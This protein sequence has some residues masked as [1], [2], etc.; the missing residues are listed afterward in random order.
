[1]YPHFMFALC[2]VSA[3]F[4][5]NCFNLYFRFQF[6]IETVESF[7][8]K[9]GS[10]DLVMN[11]YYERLLRPKA[12]CNHRYV[13]KA[14][15]CSSINTSNNGINIQ[16]YDF[17][18]NVWN[19][20]KNIPVD[21]MKSCIGLVLVNVELIFLGGYTCYLTNPRGYEYTYAVSEIVSE[22]GI[23]LQKKTISKLFHTSKSGGVI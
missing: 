10:V 4:H 8:K 12:M 19:E 22:V 1:M 23:Y 9:H 6:L 13:S 3:I 15:Y 17:A 20:F 21:A 2:D 16:K 18:E 11:E 14:I 5:L 7:Y